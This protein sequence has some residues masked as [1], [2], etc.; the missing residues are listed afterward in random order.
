MDSRGKLVVAGCAALTV[1]GSSLLAGPTYAAGVSASPE[2]ADK[3]TQVHTQFVNDTHEVLTL[4]SASRGGKTAHWERQPPATLQPGE[5]GFASSYAA[6]DASID[7][8]YT[9]ADGTTFTMHAKTPLIGSNSTSGSASSTSYRVDTSTGSG[10]NP[11]DTFTLAPGHDFSSTGGTQTFTVPAGVSKIRIVATGGDGGTY[12]NTFVP[13]GAQ[14]SGTLDVTPGEVLT[15]GVGGTGHASRS[16]A[17]GG[18]GMA[19]GDSTYAGGDGATGGDLFSGGGGGATVVL[20]SAGQT[21]VVAGG[22]GGQGADL[23]GVSGYDGG[24][25]GQGGALIG[26]V[27]DPGAGKG[28]QPGA[29]SVPQGQSAGTVAEGVGG[30]GGGGVLGGQAGVTGTGGGGGAGSSFDG[31]LT[32]ATVASAPQSGT[33]GTPGSVRIEESA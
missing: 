10:Y 33:H 30:A 26:G 3:S 28:G 32:G 24:Q 21:L 20:D 18:W 2:N 5:A 25:G 9:G 6:A 14:V 27:G 13:S 15:I 7:L 19:V 16:D 23:E 8:T 31:G 12:A 22:A 11:T 1:L 17:S 4:T 29:N